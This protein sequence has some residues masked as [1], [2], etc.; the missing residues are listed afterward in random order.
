MD[1]SAIPASHED[2]LHKKGFANLAT[3]GPRGEPQCT[4]VWYEWDGRHILVSHTKERQKY[5]NVLRDRRVALAILD[6]EDPYRY[7][8]IRGEVEVIEDDPHKRLIDALAKKYEGRERYGKDGPEV[9]R[10]IFKMRPDRVN[11]HGPSR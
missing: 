7:L 3:I 4:P 2:I 1:G 8:E 10:V 11:V 6:P 5:R 9:N